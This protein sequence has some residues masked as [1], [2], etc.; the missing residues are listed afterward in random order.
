MYP[1][2]PLVTVV[3]PTVTLLAVDAEDASNFT[4]P[5]EFL[6]YSFSSAVLI[7]NSPATRLDADGTLVAVEL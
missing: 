1:D 4:V 6:K 3:V 5:D 7:A 2:V